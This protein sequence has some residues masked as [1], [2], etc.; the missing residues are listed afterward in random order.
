MVISYNLFFLLIIVKW[1]VDGVYRR[2]N[3]GV[4]KGLVLG[5]G[6]I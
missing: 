4:E 6:I 3:R 1:E 2:E 5:S